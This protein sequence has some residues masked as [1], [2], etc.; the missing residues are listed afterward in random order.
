MRELKRELKN[1]HVF[2]SATKRN[3]VTITEGLSPAPTQQDQRSRLFPGWTS[4]GIRTKILVP[5]FLLMSLSLLGN[6]LGFLMSTNTT[7]NRILDNQLR[8]DSQRV[9]AG[10]EQREVAASQ[11]A[12]LLSGDPAL[13][14][15]LIYERIYHQ[16]NRALEMDNRVVPVRDRFSIDQV[17][18][19][20]AEDPPRARVNIAPSHLSLFTFTVGD[21]LPCDGA[22]Q[23]RLVETTIQSTPLQLLVSCA[24]VIA[25][26]HE[27]GGIQDGER[28]GTIYSVLDI[29]TTLE[30]IGRDLK[31]PSQIQSDLEFIYG[32]PP[33]SRMGYQGST[34]SQ[35]GFRVSH[36]LVDDLGGMR[37][38]LKLRLD[39][40]DINQIVDSGLYVMLIGSVITLLVLLAAGY[41]LAQSFIR[42]IVHLADVAQGVADG[43]LSRRSHLPYRDE[44]GQLG[45]SINHATETI[46]H[47]L[48][49]QARMAGE[50]QAIL[51]S[52]GDGVLAID[53]SERIVMV[54]STAGALLTHNPETLIG[55]QLDAILNVDDPVL[56]VGL[57][58]IVDQ[59]RSELIDPNRAI[60]EEQIALGSRVVRLQSA[61]TLAGGTTMTGSVVLIQDI[62]RAVESD[63]AKSEFI[64]TASH[65]MRTPLSGLKGFVDVF[66]L[67]GTDNLTEEQRSFLDTIK[68]QT[69]NM[70]QM[71]NDL[72]EMARLEQGSVRAERRW[73]YVSSAIDDALNSVTPLIEAR[74]ASVQ[75]DLAEQ[76]PCLWI[77]PL[78]LRRIFANVI[79]NA[80]K[81]V[82][83]GSGHVTI[84]AYEM[85]DSTTLLPM[86]H[87][88]PWNHAEERSVIVEIEDNGVGIRTGDQPHI[89]DRFF[90]SDNE[91]SVE[92]GGTGLGLAITA[93]LVKA[94]GGQIG[95]RSSE[96]QGTC[97]WIRL[98]A[99]STES[100]EQHERRI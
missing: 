55:Q 23:T 41:L 2:Q 53:V 66:L 35:E 54:N 42:P 86:M 64:A 92:V 88:Q 62:T 33:T 76:L 1:E 73:V 97:F 4:V 27:R 90:R 77:D 47:L 17:I 68:R 46:S 12:E 96:G 13:I 40:Q 38:L 15:A 56:L 87:E 48:E 5:L 69:D 30:R 95:F 19:F 72:L 71:V 100:L 37:A 51:Q 60:T 21:L 89:F 83:V 99:P 75:V 7:R 11:S 74:H 63:R 85:R 31:L 16:S 8:E 22:P 24:P 34:L 59:V 98:P 78:H 94:N 14:D 50:L 44:I 79:S 20:D 32:L 67:T 65:E 26:A 25:S 91:L 49:K 18:V 57:H 61:P 6:T 29:A 39:E 93:E 84:R 3:D 10:L 82:R 9:I 70:V 43:D 45:Q 52:M 58:Q 80:I 28:I 36:V 81:Y